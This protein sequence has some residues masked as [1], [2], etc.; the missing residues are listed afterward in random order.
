[1]LPDTALGLAYLPATV[2]PSLGTLQGL[3]SSGRLGL[4][5]DRDLRTALAGWGTE[6]A[7]V[8]EEELSSRELTEEDLDRVLRARINPYG[9]WEVGAAILLQGEVT[10][11]ARSAMREVPVDTEVIGVLEQ[12]RGLLWYTLVEYETL[13][14][15]IGTILTLIGRSLNR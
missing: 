2:A 9:L 7:E 3:I 10:P 1:M 6:L 11:E 13:R 14:D 5:R 4:L 12:R 15:E 8:T